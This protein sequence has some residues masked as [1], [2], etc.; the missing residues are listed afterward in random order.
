MKNFTKILMMLLGAVLLHMNILYASGSGCSDAGV[1]AASQDSLCS[2]ASATL[3]L[4]AYVGTIFQ[5]QSFDGSIWIDETGNGSNTDTYVVTPGTTT[6]FRAIV[7]AVSCPSDTSNSITIT[8]GVT[9]PTT[10]GDTRCGYGPV[11]LNAV[12]AGVI[13]WYDVPTGG[14]ALGTGPSFTTNVAATT[15]FYVAATSNGGGSGAAPLPLEVTTFT[16]NARGYWFN[17]PLTFT[18]TGLRVPDA[19]TTQNIAV[20]RFNTPTPPPV[21]ATTTNDFTVLFLTQGNTNTGV[22]P[23]NLQISAGD[24]IGI[25]GTRGAN[26]ENSYAAG[27]FVT[28]IDGQSITLERMGMQFPLA[29]IAPQD[30]WQEPGGNTSRVE[31]TYEVGCESNRT[32]AVATVNAADPITIAANPP[33]LCEGQS[34]V[35]SVSSANPNYNYTWS[36][37][38]GLSSTTGASVTANP[39][40]PITYTVVANDGTCGAIDSVFMSVGP[41]SVAGTASISTDTICAGSSAILFLTGSVG[42]IQWQYND[43]GTWMNETGSGSTSGYYPV[44]PLTT[45]QYQAVVTSGGCASVITTILNLYVLNITDPVTVNDTICG[46]G[47]VNLSATGA[48]LLNWYTSPTGGVSV[49]TTG[50]YTPNL[51]STTTYYVQASAGGNYSVG[52]ANASIGSQLV[53]IA[54]ND[55][56]LQF[57]VTQQA[58]IDRVYISPGGTGSVTINLRNTL[59]G[60][61]LNTVSTTVGAFSGLVPVN[62]GFTVNPGIG[63]RLEMASGSVNCYYNSFGPVYPYTVPGSPITITG[64]INPN[65]AAGTFYYFFYNWEVTSGCSSNRIPVTGV[66]LNAPAVPVITP[67]GNQLSSS[68]TSGNQW[69]LNGSPI[70]GANGQIYAAFQSG[71]YTVIVTDPSGCTAESLPFVYTGLNEAG[72]AEAGIAIYPNP[73]NNVLHL[74]FN[75]I[76]AGTKTINIFNA[77]GEVVKSVVVDDL[78]NTIDLNIPSGVYAVEIRTTKNIYYSNIVK[79]E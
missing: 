69:Y 16:S 79:T 53:N 42:S 5:W 75:K 31:I 47:I 8:V 25:L 40:T 10:T 46:P 14:T 24:Y 52:P 15:T 77:L 29:T 20:V 23:V 9:S 51:A 36:P 61:I 73:V 67:F 71:T 58:T 65:F 56:G 76:I 4:T 11:N 26:D 2:G 72:L 59:G 12:G 35:I 68:A 57:D 64:S 41:A 39:L 17:S 70:A 32:A 28:T 19:I 22:I 43:G 13:K 78:K 48:G 55:W 7:T 38:T 30:L 45:T 44:S 74:D 50:N 6:D 63:Y 34:S 33:A 18:I 21:F 37:S 27:L 60:A 3:S 62:L 49:N 1:A 66:V 54:G